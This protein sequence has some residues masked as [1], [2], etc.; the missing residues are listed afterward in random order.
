MQ[1]SV[2]N[3]KKEQ[4]HKE[5]PIGKEDFEGQEW[6]D[7][8]LEAEDLSL[9]KH[10]KDL[11]IQFTKITYPKKD[12]VHYCN[13]KIHQGIWR[14]K[15]SRQIKNCRLAWER[16]IRIDRLRTDKTVD[17]VLALILWRVGVYERKVLQCMQ[18]WKSQEC[19]DLVGEECVFTVRFEGRVLYSLQK[20]PRKHCI[21][22]PKYLQVWGNTLK[23]W[24]QV[25]LS[26]DP[27][28]H[29]WVNSQARLFLCLLSRQ[30]NIG[31]VFC[32]PNME[33]DW[34]ERQV[35]P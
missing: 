16:V 11:E 10:I 33:K 18:R 27:E 15:A 21:I 13:H 3:D 26:S 23:A 20:Q 4:N 22:L 25:K 19:K 24:I 34:V 14:N 2:K 31:W 8:W 6:T 12:Y 32:R 9:I 7:Q 1:I 5:L 30:G 28:F 35:F 17:R 29:R